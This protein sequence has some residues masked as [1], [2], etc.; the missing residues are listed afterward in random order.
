MKKD[1]ETTIFQTSSDQNYENDQPRKEKEKIAEHTI[2]I[3]YRWQF[4]R[5][6]VKIRIK[7]KIRPL[8]WIISFINLWLTILNNF[9]VLEFLQMM[10]LL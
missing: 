10:R 4:S 9:D 7:N 2:Y 5:K 1:F 6:K 3:L 8:V